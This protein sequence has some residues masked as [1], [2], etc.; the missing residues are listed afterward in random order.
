MCFRCHG[1]ASE[2]SPKLIADIFTELVR[3]VII[4]TPLQTIISF[5]DSSASIARRWSLF[6]FTI[7]SRG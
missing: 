3:A 4:T 1:N 5:R 6:E 2:A 7:V